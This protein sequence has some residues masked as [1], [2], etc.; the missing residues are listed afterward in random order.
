[1]GEGRGPLHSVGESNSS[2][3]LDAL[4]QRQMCSLCHSTVKIVQSVEAPPFPTGPK[5]KGSLGV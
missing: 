3:F 1:M 5:S 2:G 4:V